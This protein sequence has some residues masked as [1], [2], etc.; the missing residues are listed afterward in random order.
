MRIAFITSH[1]N[2]STQW[3]WFS[4]E[5][6]S[7]G[8]YHIHIILSDENPLLLHDLKKIGVPVYILPHFS[9][10]F[11]LSGLVG[12]MKILKKEKVDLVHTELPYGNL[13]GQ[14]AAWL[15]GIKRRV[16]TCENASWAIDNKSKKQFWIDK[17]TYLLSKKIIALTDLSK[18]YLVKKYHIPEHKLVVIGHALKIE[19]YQNISPQRIVDVRN[20]LNIKQNEFIL[21][22][23]ARGEAWKGHMYAIK[24]IELL[25][26]K[27]PNICLIMVGIDTTS[28][29]GK[30]LYEYINK[31]QLNQNVRIIK[32]VKDNIALY[33]LFNIH[34]HVPTSNMAE[35]FGITYIE[36]MISGCPQ[37]ITRSGISFF[38]AKHLENAYVVD[39]S[40]EKQI[41]EGI[42]YLIE[43]T[44]SK[45]KIAE[46]AKTLAINNFTYT[47]KVKRHLD[48]YRSL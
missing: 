22:I 41:S 26:N 44:D 14:A 45:I 24:S 2:K 30:Q 39:Y 23:V 15:S 6:K 3:N 25:K 21:G 29:Y 34:I 16:S 12:I 38:T 13:L 28:N 11:F 1:I 48:I 20:E 4:E 18:Q 46:N 35:T 42:E 47:E 32:F 7:N 9:K 37:I 43:N 36:G 10:L 27:Y 17:I 33:K 40:N 5:L 8:I 19:E 31:H